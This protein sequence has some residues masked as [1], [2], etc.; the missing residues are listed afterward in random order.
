MFDFEFILALEAFLGNCNMTIKEEKNYF[1]MLQVETPP[2]EILPIIPRVNDNWKL[3][4]E[5]VGIGKFAFSKIVFTGD[6]LFLT[7]E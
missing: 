5:K 2:I 6:I 4:I 1:G 7:L 3:K